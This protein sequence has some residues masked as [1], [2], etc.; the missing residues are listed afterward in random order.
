M[1]GHFWLVGMRE[2]AAKL[3]AELRIYS[4]P[5]A[6]TEIDLRVPANVAYKGFGTTQR[7]SWPRSWLNHLR[8]WT[9]TNA[10][11]RNAEGVR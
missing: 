7:T 1:P 11:R 9:N 4:E 5:L 2:R 3:R 6:G 10:N 8:K